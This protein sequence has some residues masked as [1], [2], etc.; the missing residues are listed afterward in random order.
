MEPRSPLEL[1]TLELW[2]PLELRSPL[3]VSPLEL[4]R[5]LE[6]RSL[7]EL[8]PLELW[9]PLELR[10]PLELGPLEL[11]SPLELRIPL[12]ARVETLNP[13]ELLYMPGRQVVDTTENPFFTVAL[14]EGVGALVSRGSGQ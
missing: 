5:P 3:E 7:L 6:L 4:W 8:S 2:S 14:D 9:R 11:R 1:R 13:L 12:E 10:C